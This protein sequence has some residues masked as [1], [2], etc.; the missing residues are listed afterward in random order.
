MDGDFNVGF[1]NELEF[2]FQEKKNSRFPNLFRFSK[3]KEKKIFN[4]YFQI[5]LNTDFQISLKKILKFY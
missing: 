2:N 3:D 4:V 5:I 1:D